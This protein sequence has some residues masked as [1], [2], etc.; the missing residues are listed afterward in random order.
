MT[1]L[2]NNDSAKAKEV[3]T[4]ELYNQFFLPDAQGTIADEFKGTIK[5]VVVTKV[6]V[7][8]SGITFIDFT[9]T[10]TDGEKENL[11]AATVVEAGKTKVDTIT[12]NLE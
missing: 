12:S 2:N 9:V 1:A 5:D 3:A 11:R 8:G 6:E 4:A 10:Y 7:Q